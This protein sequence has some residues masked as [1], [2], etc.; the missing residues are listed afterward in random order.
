MQSTAAVMPESTSPLPAVA[1]P[2]LPERLKY[3]CSS[4]SAITVQASFSTQAPRFCLQIQSRGCRILFQ[5]RNAAACQTAHLSHMR[6][7]NCI[8]IYKFLPFRMLSQK[9]QPS[10][11]MTT[12]FFAAAP[13]FK[14]QSIRSLPT[15][16][17]PSPGRSPAHRTSLGSFGWLPR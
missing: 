12:G 5:M 16:S 13:F 7:Q 9:V 1:I 2:E 10:A 11:S 8:F 3:R 6:G 4:W 17:V 15:P 14:N